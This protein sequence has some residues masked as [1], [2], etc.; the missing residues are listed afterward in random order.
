MTLR[1]MA[2][3]FGD[4]CSGNEMVVLGK[5]GEDGLEPSVNSC[6]KATGKKA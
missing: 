5:F 3:A 1:F 2:W 4:D 6:S